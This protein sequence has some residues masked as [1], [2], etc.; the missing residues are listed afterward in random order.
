MSAARGATPWTPRRVRNNR[1]EHAL[2]MARAATPLNPRRVR[3][4]RREH[5]Q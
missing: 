3:N 5:A 1:R 2:S 4:N